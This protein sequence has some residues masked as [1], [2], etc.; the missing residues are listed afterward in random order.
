MLRLEHA[1]QASGSAAFSKLLQSETLSSGRKIPRSL[2][3]SLIL[4]RY[5]FFLRAEFWA[6]Q[7]EVGELLWGYEADEAGRVML[8]ESCLILFAC[9]M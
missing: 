9:R 5:S 6:G 8:V 1:Q 2:A 3:M 4:G 7:D